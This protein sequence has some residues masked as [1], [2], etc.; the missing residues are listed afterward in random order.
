MICLCKNTSLL[1]LACA[2]AIAVLAGCDMGGASSE[3]ASKAAIRD[4]SS[5]QGRIL[6]ANQGANSV[7]LIDVATDSAYGTVPTGEQPHHVAATPDGA[8]FWVTLYKE[9]RLQVF[10]PKTLQEK[11]SVDVGGSNDD[12]TF[13]PAGKR[14]YVSLGAANAVAVV[15]VASKKLLKTVKVGTVPHG[16][17]VTPDGKLLVVTN[18]ADNTVSVLNLEPEASV[19][20]T[21]KTGAD[22]F[23]VTISEDGKT[24][25]V[26][27]FLGDSI[28]VV[29][30][31]A[32]KTVSTM[33]AGRQ[34]AML[35]LE[36]S[37]SGQ[38]LLAVANTGS[39]ELWILDPAT[40]K[41]VTRIPV[42]Q[43]A[44]GVVRTPSGKLY[45]TNSTDNTV[46]VI[47]A[48]QNKA[49]GTIPVANNPNGLAFLPNGR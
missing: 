29:D 35:T 11:A 22:P 2:F 36:D 44:H 38:K 18:T 48:T 21:I 32:G 27:N 49:V 10:D 3:P 1:V 37:G 41:L 12:I 20:A 42:G 16:L 46:S 26:S 15:D 4:M 8:E 31:S 6:T 17:K 40:R 28:S 24:A 33:K 30:I 47:D 39:A 43:G 7:T 19:K 9:N 25:Y 34:P 13:D 14:A 23:E 5:P 45:V